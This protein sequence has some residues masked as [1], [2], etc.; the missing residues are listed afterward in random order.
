VQFEKTGCCTSRDSSRICPGRIH[1]FGYLHACMGESRR[2]LALKSPKNV[3]GITMEAWERGK[4]AAVH[5]SACMHACARG[6]W[7]TQHT[8]VNAAVPCTRVYK[9]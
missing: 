7:Q 2:G 8:L 5:A 1:T 3:Q 4:P 9:W 6:G